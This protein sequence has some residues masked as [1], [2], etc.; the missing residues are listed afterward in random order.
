[1]QLSVLLFLSCNIGL[2]STRE[3]LI[4]PFVAYCMLESKSNPR[5]WIGS[6]NARLVVIDA[7]LST[8]LF[9]SRC[10]LC[11]PPQAIL[12]TS[13]R[14]RN[15]R[16]SAKSTC[17]AGGRELLQR[18]LLGDGGLAGEQTVWRHVDNCEEQDD[19]EQEAGRRAGVRLD[20]TKRLP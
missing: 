13:P 11:S 20:G 8:Q 9:E 18:R 2:L 14:H 3:W 15:P 1:V 5:C 6:V 19:D 16:R 10:C 7:S 4:K 12:H 17:R